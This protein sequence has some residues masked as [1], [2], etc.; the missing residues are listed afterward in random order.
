MIA[1]KVLEFATLLPPSRHR[2]TRAVISRRL[3]FA[4]ATRVTD[5]G[6]GA[7]VCSA[8]LRFPLASATQWL[9]RPCRSNHQRASHPSFV[10]FRAASSAGLCNR[11]RASTEECFT[12]APRSPPLPCLPRPLPLPRRLPPIPRPR[13]L[14]VPSLLSAPGRRR[15]GRLAAIRRYIPGAAW[16]CHLLARLQSQSIINTRTFSPPW[17]T[18]SSTN[19]CFSI[20]AIPSA[21]GTHPRLR[22]AQCEG[23]RIPL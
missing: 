5:K 11:R 3:L 7:I 23:W 17:A 21:L 13:P 14:L 4:L 2:E 1:D 20:A 16:L 12:L 18:L 22:S 9:A 10:W 15:A 8:S 19:S 6:R